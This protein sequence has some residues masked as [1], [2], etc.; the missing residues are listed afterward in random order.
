M[1]KYQQPVRGFMNCL[2]HISAFRIFCFVG[3]FFP[4]L[5]Q[6][7]TRLS[8]TVDLQRMNWR[9][10]LQRNDLIWKDRLPDSWDTGGFLGN[11]SLGTIFW[12][13]KPGGMDFE[14]SRSDLY[15]HREDKDGKRVLY[16]ANR[17]PNGHFTLKFGDDTLKGS[18]RLDLWN[19]ESVAD[20]RTKEGIR[21]VRAFTAANRDVIIIQVSG[22]N[23]AELQWF[24]DTAKSTRGGLP[25][26][27]QAY[28]VQQCRRNGG[29]TVSV[30]DMP[31]D[32]RYGT[33][34][35]GSGQYATA[36]RKQTTGKATIWY[37]SLKRT[38]PGQD[39][40]RSAV[41]E[42]RAAQL[43]GVERLRQEH[44]AWWHQYYPKS[45]LS[46]PDAPMESFYW[47][48]IY[49]MGAASR[50]GGPILD[51]M[52]PWFRQTV[53]PAIWW[54]LNIQLAYWPYYMANHLDEAEPLARTVWE[55]REMLAKNAA[56]FQ[57]DSYAIG[58]A[59]GPGG[60]SPVGTE[61]GNLPWVMHNL[62][63]YYRSTMDDGY[64][65]HQLF[66]L[67][68]GTFNYL[69]HIT[70]RTSDGRL[71]LP[72]T[73]SPEYTDGVENSSY[74]LAC[75]R[76]LAATIITA[77]KRLHLD[78]SIALRCRQ[79]LN[80]LV[81]YET[82][83]QTGLM[84]GKNLPF[85]KSHRHWSHLFAI[86]PFH[87]MK[88]ENAQQRPL[89]RK[90]LENW[91]SMPQAFAG[92]S[93][94]GAASMLA[95]GNN[96]D[97]ALDF[98]HLF[99]RKSP[100]PNTL[101][102]EGSPVIETPLAFDR[103]LQEMMMTS[104]DDTIR[105][106]PGLPAKWREVSFA[107]FRAEGAFLVS[108]KRA[109]GVTTVIVIKSLAGEPCV[110]QTG[111]ASPIRAVG[112]N[113]ERVKILDHGRVGLHLAKGETVILFPGNGAESL[114]FQ[115]VVRVDQPELWGGRKAAVDDKD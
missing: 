14:I 22:E 85:A 36:W 40:E 44:Q 75:L 59:S 70:V 107:N 91:V 23:S 20:I 97:K 78:D 60:W 88:W 98:L 87:E 39:A 5:A 17:L 37:I 80:T 106:F 79:V 61:V 21:Q 47:V 50:S 25:K 38:L 4:G 101:Y 74:T 19:A 1:K 6:A 31:E 115:P 66:P 113:K 62:W 27:Y 112:V 26:G 32:E 63:M 8:N 96:G 48:Q 67:M 114:V 58:R 2:I 73:A 64:L 9:A 49:K 84:V 55:D 54:N 41:G 69:D 105:I 56:P 15:D 18:M 90:S 72:K 30:Q 82:D 13:R 10:F 65:R 81:P 28:P 86:Y 11:G 7:Q 83:V 100:L 89:I 29:V 104:F 42:V 108:A 93:W 109:K 45:F 103:T 33:A 102:R 76:W 99:I 52:G 94:L 110:V 92:Y 12:Q 68:K 111:Y 53:W 51:L 35:K 95:A 43:L 77:D 24:P 3:L 71:M 16:S 34:G 46:I 57:Q